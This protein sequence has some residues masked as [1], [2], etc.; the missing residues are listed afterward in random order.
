VRFYT[1]DPPDSLPIGPEWEALA[2]PLSGASA[3]PLISDPP[4]KRAGIMSE[5]TAT[6]SVTFSGPFSLADVACQLWGD[7]MS[8]DRVRADRYLAFL[9]FALSFLFLFAV[10]ALAFINDVPPASIAATVAK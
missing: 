7:A 6:L 2:Y 1:S 4:S 3:L 8:I 5:R 9:G 10:V